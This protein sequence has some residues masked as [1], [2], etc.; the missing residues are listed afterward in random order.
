MNKFFKQ[1]LF[2]KRGITAQGM[3]EFALVLPILLVLLFG[4][5]EFGRIFQA[6]LSVQNSARF[7]VRY[8]VTGQYDTNYCDDAAVAEVNNDIFKKYLTNNITPAVNPAAA[9]TYNGS[10]QDCRIPLEFANDLKTRAPFSSMAP[11]AATLAIGDTIQNMT[12]ILQDYAR[13]QSIRDITRNDAFAIAMDL[14]KTNETDLGYFKVIVLSTRVKTYCDSIHVDWFTCVTYSNPAAR[15][16]WSA[17][18]SGFEDPGGPGDSVLIGVDFN[19]PLITPFLMQAWPY[20][21][22]TT[23]REGI[24]ENFRSSKTVNIAPPLSMPS[25]TA[26]MTPSITPTPTNT[27]TP[28]FTASPTATETFTP[29]PTKTQTETPTRTLTLTPSKTSTNTLTLTPSKTSTASSTPTITLTPSR[30]P[31]NTPTLVPSC[32]LLTINLGMNGARTDRLQADIYNGNSISATFGTVIVDWD[33]SAGN[34]NVYLDWMNW[35]N[36]SSGAF[37]GGNAY[38]A[39]TTGT[40]SGKVLASNT[41]NSMY[42]DFAPDSRGISGTFTVSV[43]VTVN[44]I[45]CPLTDTY[46][47]VGPTA[48]L[49]R[50][51]TR[52][53]TPSLTPT[54]TLTPTR[55]NTPT[56]TLTPTKTYTP[57]N[58]FTPS[59]TPTRTATLTPSDTP[60]PPTITPSPTRTNTVAPTYTFT[61]SRTPTATR[62]FTATFTATDTVIPSKTPT[63][64]QAPTSTPSRTPTPTSTPTPSGCGVDC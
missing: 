14:T 31:T 20:L 50:T 23:Y 13:L 60:I 10:P 37:Y 34:S 3:V 40:Q 9:D 12:N 6:W 42:I 29:S 32:G 61:P 57:T 44:G 11:D 64:T 36:S 27:L 43:T 28:T 4:I 59:R 46:T 19:H 53:F 5:I 52:T 55:T 16:Y 1:K 30:T 45:N 24:I 51:P 35:T 63:R 25:P 22:L 18:P 48:T 26:S 41:T 62:T 15:K 8:A 7:A 47:R 2:S 54:N 56:I 17:G 21:H 38:T 49:T 33:D 58:T 39:P